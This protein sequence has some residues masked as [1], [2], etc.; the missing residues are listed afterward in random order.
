M[1]FPAKGKPKPLDTM[2]IQRIGFASEMVAKW[3]QERTDV[4][5]SILT[6][7][8]YSNK[9]KIYL[10]QWWYKFKTK[11]TLKCFVSLFIT[12]NPLM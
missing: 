5:V 12:K 8:Y 9:R 2:D 10:H 3:I 6:Y 11:Y 4:Q 1:H 7:V